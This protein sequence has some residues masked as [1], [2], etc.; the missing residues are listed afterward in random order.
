MFKKIPAAS[1][2]Q[3]KTYFTIFFSSVTHV[4]QVVFAAAGRVLDSS[5]NFLK[6]SVITP[7]TGTPAIKSF[8]QF[9]GGGE[10]RA[11]VRVRQ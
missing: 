10:I 6:V 8:Q 3:R 11:C 1:N 5:L 9:L 2:C 4:F 7:A